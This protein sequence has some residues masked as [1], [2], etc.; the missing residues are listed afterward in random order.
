ME[1]T[2]QRLQPLVR[3]DHARCEG[4]INK[5][6]ALEDGHLKICRYQ[7]K[8]RMRSLQFT[9]YMKRASLVWWRN[10]AVHMAWHS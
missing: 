6:G 1:E 10:T 3:P 7:L 2:V 9:R 4:D 5:D 8:R